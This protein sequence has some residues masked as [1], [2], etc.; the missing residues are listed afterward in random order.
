MAARRFLFVMWEGGGNVPPQLG[1]ARKLVARGH[2]VR[3]LTEPSVRQDVRATGAS[4]S[5]FANAPH[6]TTAHPT[7]TWSATSTPA[8]RPAPSPPSATA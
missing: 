4:S 8:P 2:Q 7:A 3:V 5:S 6:P 1:L